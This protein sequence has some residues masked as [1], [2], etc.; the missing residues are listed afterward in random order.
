MTDGGDPP[1]AWP[2][3][4]VCA[5]NTPHRAGFHGIAPTAEVSTP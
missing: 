4:V 2:A 1:A 3:I 5:K